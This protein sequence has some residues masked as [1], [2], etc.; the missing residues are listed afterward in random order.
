MKS[1]LALLG[2]GEKPALTNLDGARTLLATVTT[3]AEKLGKMFTAA[4]LDLDALLSNG[5]N[6]LAD[7]I[8]TA[9]NA[10]RLQAT[11]D[12]HAALLT[13]LGIK[14]AEGQ[15]VAVA[16]KAALDANVSAATQVTALNGQ[17][18]T[19]NIGLTKAGVVVKASDEKKGVQESDIVTAVENRISLKAA[20]L[21]GRLGTAPVDPS[22]NN[23]PAAAPKGE[24]S[25]L[26][27]LA[28]V[29]AAFEAESLAAKSRRN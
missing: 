11:T 10:A 15:T 20:E 4:S 18:A 22:L 25:E 26:K 8:A 1:F 27:G 29:Q 13:E 16:I 2:L 3:N 9:L 6:A 19:L 24:K 12:A 7:H 5:D 23:N 14:P 21:N 28:K 17:L